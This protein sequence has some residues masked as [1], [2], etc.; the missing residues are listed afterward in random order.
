MA[1][2][3]R[4]GSGRG[5]RARK[6]ASAPSAASRSSGPSYRWTQWIAYTVLAIFAL[7][8]GI[9]AFTVHT[10]GNYGVETDYYWKY[11]PAA[12]DLLKGRIAIENYDSKGWGYPATIALVSML[13]FDLFRAAQIIALLSAVAVGLFA[14]RIHR[15]LLGPSVALGSLLIMLFNDTFLANTYEVGTDMFFFAI[16]L[17]SILLLLG[18]SNPSWWAILASGLLGGWAFSTRYNGLFLW[19]GALVL[20]LLIRTAEGAAAVRWRRAAL[21]TA[22]FFAAALPWLLINAAHTGNPLT[23]S[24]YMNVAYTVYGEGNWEKFFYGGG[25]QKVHSFVDLVRM[26]PGRFAGAMAKNSIDHLGRNLREL[27]PLAWGFFAV[28]GALLFL[29]ERPGRRFAGYVLLCAL[30]FLTVIPIF[31]GARFSLPLLAFLALLAAWPFASP[32]AGKPLQ[33]IERMFPLRTFLFLALLLATAFPAYQWTVD[34][35]NKERV[36]TA[37]RDLLP[38]IAYLSANAAGETLMARKPHAAFMS[39]MRFEP[40]PQ[41]DTPEKLHAAAEE[42]RVRYILVSPAEILRREAIQPFA[43]GDEVPGFECVFRS[44]GVY[45]YEVKGDSTAPPEAAKL[46]PRN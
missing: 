25:N 11:G 40:I 15:S 46:P 13:G 27:L 23:N 35:A 26:D 8:W 44:P 6:G 43:R 5:G 7:Y 16:M 36:Q 12:R 2:P 21:W 17:G 20:L 32:L 28:I 22:G 29:R 42:K 19:P 4:G 34:P 10:M 31:Y 45:V 39:G 24:N 33:G 41:V 30:F 9:K 3:A 38:S 1:K 37:P 18:R 14:Y